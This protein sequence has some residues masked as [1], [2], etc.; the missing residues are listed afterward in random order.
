[1][2]SRR[3]QRLMTPDSGNANK[4]RRTGD[5]SP[6]ALEDHL[7]EAT[8][9]P[10]FQ[11]EELSDEQTLGP[12]TPDEDDARYYDPDQDPEERRMVSALVRDHHRQ[13]LGKWLGRH[14]GSITKRF[15]TTAT[16]YLRST[17]TI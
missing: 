12:P 4:R 16:R 17:A 11:D 2:A 3:A 6:G 15:Q 7:D 1:M 10:V 9:M 14:G 13:V 5:Y 8:S